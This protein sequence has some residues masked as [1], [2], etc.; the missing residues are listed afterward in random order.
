MYLARF[1]LTPIKIYICLKVFRKYLFK[2][3]NRVNKD[4]I[5]KGSTN[6]SDMEN[7]RRASRRKFVERF[8][9][10]EAA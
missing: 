2:N 10:E 7:F 4:A 8:S 1:S 3:I 6:K 9:V 5:S